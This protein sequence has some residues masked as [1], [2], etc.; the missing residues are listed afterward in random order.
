MQDAANGSRKTSVGNVVDSRN[1]DM[2]VFFSQKRV[3][4]NLIF[5]K[6]IFLEILL[7]GIV[8]LEHIV[9]IFDRTLT[10]T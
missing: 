9:V 8:M 10:R 2:N 5:L 4:G 3:V 1:L 7:T 6:N